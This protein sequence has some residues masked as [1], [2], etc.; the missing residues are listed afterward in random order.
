MRAGD[1]LSRVVSFSVWWKPWE[2]HK[3]TCNIS[4]DG[5]GSKIQTLTFKVSKQ[6]KP[7]KTVKKEQKKRQ[8]KRK[9]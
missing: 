1:T 8:K 4:K 5:D 7:M 9:F 2:L 3:R 6:K